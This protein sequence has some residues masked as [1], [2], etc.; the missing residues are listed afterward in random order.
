MHIH[1]IPAVEAVLEVD[2]MTAVAQLELK[3]TL[4][5]PRSG[6]WECRKYHVDEQLRGRWHASPR[7][8]SDV[9]FA[10]GSRGGVS[11]RR[12]PGRAG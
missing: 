11:T 12:H 9:T 4:T 6:A 8:Q 1:A 5:P 10:G 3:A 7:R 2:M